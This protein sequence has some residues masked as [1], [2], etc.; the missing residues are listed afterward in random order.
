MH[1]VAHTLRNFEG[2]IEHNPERAALLDARLEQINRIKRKYGP[3]IEEVYAYYNQTK[4]RLEKLENADAD[5][6]FL[7]KKT[8]NLG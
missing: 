7:Q 3:S 5:I 2:S 1:E 8:W 6:E 4:T